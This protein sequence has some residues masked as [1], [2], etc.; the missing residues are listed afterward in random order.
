MHTNKTECYENYPLHFVVFST[1]VALSIYILGAVILSGVGLLAVI[2][3]LLYCILL[4]FRLFRKSCVDCYYYGKLCFSG[5]GLL[6]SLF[7]KKGDPKRFIEKKIVWWQIIP[8]FLVTLIPL[9]GGIILSII[10]F[11]WLRI[12]L[13]IMLAIL[14]FPITGY[15]RS[16]FA[17]SYCK[18]RELG[19]PAAELFSGK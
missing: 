7:F 3:Y 11:N 10:D 14:G 17:C 6:C 2:S 13:I 1:L 8:D 16:S 5:K 12:G 9:I 18:Q 4:E 15:I 19:C